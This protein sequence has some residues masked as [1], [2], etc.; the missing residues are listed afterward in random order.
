MLRRR[1][2][3]SSLRLS[4]RS[5]QFLVFLMVCNTTSFFMD[6]QYLLGSVGIERPNF[7]AQGR[8]D[9]FHIIL[10]Q[11][12][13]SETSG[14]QILGGE[15]LHHERFSNNL[16]LRWL[17]ELPC[18]RCFVICQRLSGQAPRYVRLQ[19]CLSSGST[20]GTASR[21]LAYLFHLVSNMTTGKRSKTDDSLSISM[22]RSRMRSERTYPFA[23]YSA[24]TA[25]KRKKDQSLRKTQSE[26]VLLTSCAWF[27]TL[28]IRVLLNTCSIFTLV[29]DIGRYAQSGSMQVTFIELKFFQTCSIH[30]R[31]GSNTHH[32]GCFSSIGILESD[33]CFMVFL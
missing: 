15:T 9:R 21:F 32:Q 1:T 4:L 7:L 24:A 20:R 10:F 29:D 28:F 13:T 31:Y 23:R 30:H 17:V 12:K 2:C 11:R 8:C 6:I 18:R 22:A 19:T 14:E 26:I 33:C 5:G 16:S 3:G 27:V 25:K